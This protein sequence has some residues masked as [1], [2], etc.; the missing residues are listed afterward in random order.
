[1]MSDLPLELIHDLHKCAYFMRQKDPRFNWELDLVLQAYCDFV[2]EN[3]AVLERGAYNEIKG[4][5]AVNFR[6]VITE[7]IVR[8][9]IPELSLEEKV[10]V[11][12]D[13]MEVPKDAA[14]KAQGGPEK[15]E[16]KMLEAE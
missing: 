4:R 7:D 16:F 8:D 14:G 10:L 9:N 1:M 13:T 2:I 5:P 11:G 3:W 15:G 6:Q 12:M